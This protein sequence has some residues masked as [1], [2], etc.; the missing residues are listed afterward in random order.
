M[1]PE[2]YKENI[3]GFMKKHGIDGFLEIYFTKF[4]FKALKFQMKSSI[5]ESRRISKDPGIAFYLHN[6]KI[7]SVEDVKKFEKD[8][9]NICNNVAKQMIKELKEDKE[10]KNLFSG[11]LK[12]IQDKKL[13]EKFTKKLHKIIKGLK[14]SK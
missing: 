12:K 10:F 9:Q 7:G 8:L 14:Y 6:K 3:E 2:N 5:G 11:D 1:N 4:L 13:E